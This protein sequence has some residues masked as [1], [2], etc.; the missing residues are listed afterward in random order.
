MAEAPFTTGLGSM[1]AGDV[2]V[3][4]A[5]PGAATMTVDPGATVLGVHAEGGAA[6]G[7]VTILAAGE[8]GPVI[9][10][11]ADLPA[12][13]IADTRTALPVELAAGAY[14]ISTTGTLTGYLTI[15]D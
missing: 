13:A 4:A 3:E 6:G 10:Y 11:E 7:T 9:Y 1:H 12:D 5:G 14:A 8:D 15:P 2:T